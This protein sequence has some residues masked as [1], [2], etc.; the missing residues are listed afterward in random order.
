M[1]G[2]C[3]ENADNAETVLKYIVRGMRG[4]RGMWERFKM[5][6]MENLNFEETIERFI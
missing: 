4:K 5:Q 6:P 1:C 2:E 3:G